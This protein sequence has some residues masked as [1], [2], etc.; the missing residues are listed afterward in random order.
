VP[1]PR[2]RTKTTGLVA[3]PPAGLYAPPRGSH[4][5]GG[6]SYLRSHPASP[7]GAPGP[8]K[9]LGY[10]K[11]TPRPG[12]GPGEGLGGTTK[13]ALNS[14]FCRSTSVYIRYFMEIFGSEG[15]F[16]DPDPQDFGS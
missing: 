16:A 8:D 3:S 1:S 7:G 6:A 13:E 10:A 11:A 15:T 12:R 4:L 14:A 2:A 9:A 5:P